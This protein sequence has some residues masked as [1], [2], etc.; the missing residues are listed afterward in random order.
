MMRN[1]TRATPPIT[2][3]H[4]RNPLSCDA[5]AMPLPTLTR[6]DIQNAITAI[7]TIRNIPHGTSSL[8]FL[9]MCFVDLWQRYAFV[10]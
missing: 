2:A 3:S 4:V 5:A 10:L 9:L 6:Q 8:L 1:V 7:V